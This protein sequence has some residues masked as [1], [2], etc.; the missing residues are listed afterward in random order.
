MDYHQ[1][2]VQVCVLDPAGS[3]LLNRG[4]ANRWQAIASAVVPLG[5]MRGAAIEVSC[6]AADLAEELVDKAG[7]SVELAHPGY[8]ARMKG[9]P[10]KTDF[11]DARLLADLTRVGY[12]PRVWLAPPYLRELRRLVRYRQQQVD[13]RRAIKL[14]ITGLLRDHRLRP[15]ASVKAWSRPWWTWLF[16][17]VLLT[18]PK[19]SAWILHRH[20]ERLKAAGAEIASVEEA[21]R[22]YPCTDSVVEDLLEERGVG[23]VTA[24]G[25]RAEIGQFDRFGK[26]KSLSRFCGLSPRNASSGQ[27]MADAGLVKAGSNLLRATLIELAHR[28]TRYEPRWRA[29]K[30][31]MRADGKPGSVAA[32]AVA[33]R[34]MRGLWHRMRERQLSRQQGGGELVPWLG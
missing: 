23:E 21:L 2:S 32:A 30:E 28:L 15:A 16:E 24:W 4:L 19:A 6:G 10:D 1:S 17:E 20:V 8:V 29:M 27:R 13:Q 25:I 31:H 22:E 9:S 34:W 3:I 7:W 26:A 11:S 14:R 33:N 18:M 5:R 12:L